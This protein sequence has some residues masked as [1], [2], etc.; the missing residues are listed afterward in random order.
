MGAYMVL[1]PSNRFIIPFIGFAFFG[2]VLRTPAWAFIGFWGVLQAVSG[3]LE[4]PAIAWWDHLG[5]LLGG[6]VVGTI[7]RLADR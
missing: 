3:L 4:L 7:Y 5:G 1:F 6:V 2:T